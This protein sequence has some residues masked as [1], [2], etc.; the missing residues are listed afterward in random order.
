MCLFYLEV[1]DDIKEIVR[2]NALK[3][4]LPLVIHNGHE[5]WNMLKSWMKTYETE[6]QNMHF[7][8]I[9]RTIAK[10]Q[11][12]DMKLSVNFKPA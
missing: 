9:H 11:G 5:G 4:L 6:Y 7:Q 1:I 2:I 8:E 10:L 3:T 12:G